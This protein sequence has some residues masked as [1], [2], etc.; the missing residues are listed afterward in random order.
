M[1]EVDKGVEGGDVTGNKLNEMGDKLSL[2]LIRFI[3]DCH[4]HFSLLGSLT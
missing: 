2:I 1:G 3:R 4:T